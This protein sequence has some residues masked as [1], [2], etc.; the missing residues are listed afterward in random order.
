MDEHYRL[1]LAHEVLRV[2]HYLHENRDQ[3]MQMLDDVV[4]RIL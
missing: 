1:K 4:D 3:C 2:R